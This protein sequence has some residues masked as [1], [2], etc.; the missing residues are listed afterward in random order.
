MSERERGEKWKGWFIILISK[1]KPR[2]HGTEYGRQRERIRRS[3]EEVERHTEKKR[4]SEY[5]IYR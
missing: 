2:K 5:Y 1:S 4:D 3:R